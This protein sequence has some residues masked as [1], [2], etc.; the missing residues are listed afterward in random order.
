MGEGYV[1]HDLA[2]LDIFSSFGSDSLLLGFDSR[3]ECAGGRDREFLHGEV[4]RE[5]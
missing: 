1:K 3:E 4:G 5:E 2:A